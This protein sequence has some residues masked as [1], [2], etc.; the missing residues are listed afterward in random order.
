MTIATLAKYKK[1]IAGL[2]GTLVGLG[3]ALLSLGVLSG[4]VS[5]DLAVGLAAAT[6]ILTMLG[7]AVAPA[8]ATVEEKTAAE[9]VAA[10][11]AEWDSIVNAVHGATIAP[12]APVAVPAPTPEVTP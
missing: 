5:H 6:P 3:G 9:L 11:K 10:T 1:A 4:P 2:L 7:V 12:P 8:N